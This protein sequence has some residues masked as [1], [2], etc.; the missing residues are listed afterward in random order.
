MEIGALREYLSYDPSTGKFA[1]RK[2]PSKNIN[3]GDPAGYHSKIGYVQIGLNGK[4]YYGHRLAWAIHYG[5]N[6]PKMID[7]INNDKSDNRICNL[8]SASNAENMRN[9]GRTKRNK[10]GYKGVYYH[11]KNKKYIAAIGKN[12]KTIYVGS[13]DTIEEAHA[14]YCKAAEKLHGPYAKS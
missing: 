6:P 14:A 1:W 13:F 9:M 7:H 2:K 4:I 8:R 12:M 10:T 11:K 5:E 3:M